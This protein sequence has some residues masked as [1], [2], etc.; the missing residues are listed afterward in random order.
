MKNNKSCGED[1]ISTESLKI[2]EPILL[3]YLT[4]LFNNILQTGTF[5]KDF[6]HSNIILLHKKGDKSDINNYRP[7]SLISHIYK[8]FIKIIENRISRELDKQ[9]P[10][11]QAGFRPGLST[12]D[13]LHTVNQIIEKHQE[14][15]IPLH[16]AFVDYSKAFDSIT[17]TAI[18][19]ALRRQQIDPT[20]INL[21]RIIYKN[22]TAAIK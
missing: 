14:Y 1:G 2:G 22:S 21:L 10:P 17:H 19:D 9:Q 13:H 15:K 8:I 5:P 7:I 18:F 12:T 4:Q 16:L 6:C 20:Y 3:H 11:E